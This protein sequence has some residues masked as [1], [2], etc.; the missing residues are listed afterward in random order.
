VQPLPTDKFP[1]NAFPSEVTAVDSRNHPPTPIVLC[2]RAGVLRT[3]VPFDAVDGEVRVDDGVV[4][5][6]IEHPD[7]STLDRLQ[8]EL[9]L[10]PLAIQDLR[11]PHQRPKVDEY[12]GFT[13][14]VLFAARLTQHRRLHLAQIAIFAGPGYIVTVHRDPVPALSSVRERW[15]AT[16]RLMDPHPHELLLYRI[17][18]AM[19]EAYFPLVDAFDTR[20]EHIEDRLFRRFD[21]ALLQELLMLR[22]DLTELRRVV[23]P[24]RDVFTTLSRHD[25]PNVGAFVAPYFIDLVDLILRL[26]D[27]IDTMRDRLGTGLDSYLTLQSNAL[28]ETMKR[29][30]ALTVIFTIP[31]IVTGIYGM[32]FDNLPELHWGLGYPFA[33]ALAAVAIGAAVWVFKSK[34]WL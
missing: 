16:P 26:T 5:L 34:D 19:V 17:C 13:M 33:L 4:W 20:I 27:T 24:P 21:R 32:N 8:E 22:R 12:D 31:M 23:A 15:L 2:Y 1:D 14:V 6:D 25:D 9:K 28:N 7:A 10:H 30:T 29:L 3:D 11:L 18:A